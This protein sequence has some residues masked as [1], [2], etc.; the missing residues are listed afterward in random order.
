MP[1]SNY[2]QVFCF[3]SDTS[4]IGRFHDNHPPAFSRRRVIL[5]ATFI[6]DVYSEETGD[7]SV[8]PPSR[9]QRYFLLFLFHFFGI[10][11]VKVTDPLV[12][13]VID[14]VF[15][16]AGFIFRLLLI[17]SDCLEDFVSSLCLE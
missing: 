14:I 2:R 7:G 12:G 4:N 10:T 9:H 15:D 8:S 17:D 11:Q 6:C 13:L 5:H 16:L 1:K 3:L